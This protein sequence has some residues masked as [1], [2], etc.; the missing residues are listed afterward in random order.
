M[1]RNTHHFYIKWPQIHISAKSISSAATSMHSWKKI[2]SIHLQDKPWLFPERLCFALP[3]LPQK[4][5]E[6][7][8]VWIL[9]QYQLHNQEPCLDVPKGWI[10]MCCCEMSVKS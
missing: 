6:V 10:P 7:E 8:L 3:D 4:T 1:S 9:F 2:S 5:V